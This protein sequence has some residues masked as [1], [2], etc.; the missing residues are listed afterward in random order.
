M[1]RTTCLVLTSTSFSNR[2]KLHASQYEVK[3]DKRRTAASKKRLISP[4]LDAISTRDGQMRDWLQ[5]RCLPSPLKKGTYTLPISLFEAVE[6]EI[7]TY[8]AEREALVDKFIETYP[9]RYDEAVIALDGI[10]NAM[11][12]PVSSHDLRAFPEK[13]VLLRRQFTADRRYIEFSVSSDLR[14]IDPQLYREEMRKAA[15]EWQ[16]LRD[17]ISHL[18]R[19]EMSDLVTDM[20]DKLTGKTDKGRQKV[21]RATFLP[22]VNDWLSVIQSRNIVDDARLSALAD[23]MR[24]MLKGVDETALK[25]SQDCRGAIQQGF[26]C[27][28]KETLRD[29]H[30][31]SDAPHYL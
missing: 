10:F 22:R 20:L 18:L 27:I 30:R 13:E 12:Y 4:E 2:R 7:Q 1:G 24:D 9:D 15:R 6:A 28:S 8:F 23:Q 21:V 3:G 14:E 31:S 5:T 25:Q 17:G 11:D 16:E 29:A 19:Q 26:Q